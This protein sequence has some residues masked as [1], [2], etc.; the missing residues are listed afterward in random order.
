MKTMNNLI[1]TVTGLLSFSYIVFAI[2]VYIRAFINNS[3]MSIL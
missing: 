1:L 3:Q 2:V